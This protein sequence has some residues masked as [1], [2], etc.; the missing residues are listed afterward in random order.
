MI[1][2]G[3][4]RPLALWALG[5][6]VLVGTGSV[7]AF[8]EPVLLG[9]V[10]F[11]HT[12]AL[13][14]SEDIGGG[15]LPSPGVV[16]GIGHGFLPSLANSVGSNE[17]FAFQATG[18]RDFNANSPRFDQLV[19][20]ITNG[21]D[22]NLFTLVTL[23]IPNSSVGVSSTRR[24][25]EF[26]E[27]DGAPDLAG[28]AVSFVR[29]VVTNSGGVTEPCQQPQVGARIFVS[30]RWEFWGTPS[31][32][33]PTVALSPL[34]CTTCHIGGFAQFKLTITNPGP[35]RTVEVKVASRFPDGVTI[36]SI[37]DPSSQRSLGAGQVLEETLP[38]II[39]PSGLPFG[40][41]VLEAALLEP[42]LG[43]SLARSTFP[44]QLV[45]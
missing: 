12:G 7:S 10:N 31:S 37:L 44:A 36:F 35:A 19:Q 15:T 13:C 34:G 23:Q 9:Q 26:P 18:S 38:G 39:I 45:P 1:A 27:L 2:R 24:E 30:G 16:F 21:S 28:S 25:S 5:V 17:P 33:P 32:F 3:W 4:A 29:L 42:Q 14:T 11:N 40:T 20:S 8:A 43:E 41:Y 6:A 22:E